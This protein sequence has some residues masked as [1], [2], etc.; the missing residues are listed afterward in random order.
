MDAFEIKSKYPEAW[1]YACRRG[2][3]IDKA[4]QELETEQAV[5]DS[6]QR[7]HE[8]Q[9]TE[10]FEKESTE[11]PDNK[12]RISTLLDEI[13]TD[14]AE[15][16]IAENNLDEHYESILQKKQEDLDRKLAL[17]E[18]FLGYLVTQSQQLESQSKDYHEAIQ[19]F[20]DATNQFLEL[21]KQASAAVDKYNQLV[22]DF[23]REYDNK[24]HQLNMRLNH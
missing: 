21:A 8:Q 17:T 2:I 24:I 22:I 3:S 10:D 6:I 5:K 11:Q 12:E 14:Y 23:E 20:N 15:Q 9:Q 19:A 18:K 13:E 16:K 4:R 1:A 7:L